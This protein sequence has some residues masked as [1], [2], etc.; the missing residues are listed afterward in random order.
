[1]AAR[2]VPLASAFNLDDVS[3]QPREQLRTRRPGL[4]VR[5]IEDAN[6]V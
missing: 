2:D 3:A 4:N 5:E 1:L 6:A